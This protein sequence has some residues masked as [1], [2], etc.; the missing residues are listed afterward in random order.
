MSSE[1]FELRPTPHARCLFSRLYSNNIDR[2][3]FLA[4]KE[5]SASRDEIENWRVRQRRH[6]KNPMRF[7]EPLTPPLSP[8]SYLPPPS[9]LHPPPS[10]LVRLRSQPPCPRSELFSPQVPVQPE[11]D[12]LILACDGVWDA[13]SSQQAVSFVH[14]RLIN[15]R[16]VQ[17]ASHEV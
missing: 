7:P 4:G 14:R 11:D 16:D 13:V 10:P 9:S 15:H 12:F 8:Y 5:Q 6:E 2:I 17:R 1:R 3:L